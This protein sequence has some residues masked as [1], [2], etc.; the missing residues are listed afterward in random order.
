MCEVTV[1]N[2]GFGKSMDFS[3]GEHGPHEKCNA[4]VT[5]NPDHCHC[6]ELWA[7]VFWEAGNRVLEAI[8]KA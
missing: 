3:H 8:G 1:E 6:K 4:L 7:V 5:R 2:F